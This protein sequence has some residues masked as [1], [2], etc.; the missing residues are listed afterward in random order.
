MNKNIKMGAAQTVEQKIGTAT[1]NIDSL[2]TEIDVAMKEINGRANWL[3]GEIKR[4]NYNTPDLCNKLTYHRVGELTSHFPLYTIEETVSQYPSPVL[5]G[6]QYRLG[7]EPEIAQDVTL[8]ALEPE[9]KRVCNS[10]I[11]FYKR[12][13][14]LVQQIVR[15]LPKCQKMERQITDDL[16]QKLQGADIDKPEWIN[17]YNQV[18]KFNKT[19]KSNYSKIERALINVQEAQTVQQLNRVAKNVPKL[20][21]S[22]TATCE[23]YKNQ[24]LQFSEPLVQGVPQKPLPELPVEEDAEVK[25]NIE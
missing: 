4:R 11:N 14:D 1:G 19:I 17:V 23:T 16:S 18:Q 22:T 13:I 12:K 7:V 10:I 2:H 5:R 3:I 25:V 24:L 21:S 8:L 20:L 15:E 9:K 6:V